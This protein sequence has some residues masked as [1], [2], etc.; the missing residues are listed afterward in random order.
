MFFVFFVA[1]YF[2]CKLTNLRIWKIKRKVRTI[3]YFLESVSSH[4]VFSH[5]F[6]FF[7]YRDILLVTSFLDLKRIL[8]EILLA[9]VRSYLSIEDTVIFLSIKQLQEVYFSPHSPPSQKVYFSSLPSPSPRAHY[10][11]CLYVCFEI[12]NRINSYLL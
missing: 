3:P 2:A 4:C 6:L 1:W 5:L 9:A 8:R 12:F 11:Y 10:Y 7:I